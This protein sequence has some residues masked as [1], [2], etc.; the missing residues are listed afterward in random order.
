MTATNE[1]SGVERASTIRS[2]FDRRSWLLAQI[3][4]CTADNQAIVFIKPSG[5]GSLPGRHTVNPNNRLDL[6]C[7]S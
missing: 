7:L 6:M 3:G 4:K 1:H 2:E 5:R